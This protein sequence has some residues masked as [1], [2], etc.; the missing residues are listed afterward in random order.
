VKY[1]IYNKCPV[2]TFCTIHDFFITSWLYCIV[3][4]LNNIYVQHWRLYSDGV[5]ER[6]LC[7]VRVQEIKYENHQLG[8]NT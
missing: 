4:K 2:V 8:I 6:K 7:C 3:Y 5:K 1:L